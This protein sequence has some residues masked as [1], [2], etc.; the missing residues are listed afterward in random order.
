MKG[1][2]VYNLYPRL[3]GKFEH[4]KTHAKRAQE[5]G[6]EYIYLN[7]VAA[8]G[9]SGSSYAV[10]DYYLYH[11]MHTKGWP[12]EG[13]DYSEENLI[14]EKKIAEKNFKAFIKYCEKLGLKVMLDLV[15]NHT[16]I[17]STLA[18]E[19][20]EWY[21]KDDEGNILNPGADQD[22]EW[23]TWGDLASIDND[24]SSEKTELWNYWLKLLNYYLTLGIKGFRCDAAYHIPVDL[25]KFLIENIRKTDKNVVFLG[26]TLGCTPK[27]LM[28]IGDAGFDILMNSFKWWDMKAPWFLKDYNLWSKNYNSLCF[29][30]NHDTV[31][32][33][34]EFDGNKEKAVFVYT[35]ES[36]FCSSIAITLGFEYGF[37]N[38]IDVVTTNPTDYEKIS[39]DITQE[40][41]TINELKKSCEIFKEDNFIETISLGENLFVF[42]KE[43]KDKKEIMVVMVNLNENEWERV[44]YYNF[45]QLFNGEIKDL[46][47][48]HKMDKVPNN[49]EY[50]LKPNEIKI[51]YSKK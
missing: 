33:A 43:S 31:R 39:Y 4:M 13:E 37:Q 1:I 12:L 44:E 20:K 50:F 3:I 46:S 2:L 14:K 23:I 18:K 21:L 17:D 36:L 45:S 26:E 11:P 16:A 38:K 10:K 22:G 34:K 48:G 42:R 29:P 41:K 8:S 49:F 32:F 5:M 28:A 51:F 27:E 35:L 7:P 15:I 25:W 30:E 6:F 19:H 40:I 9:F 24:N 47:L